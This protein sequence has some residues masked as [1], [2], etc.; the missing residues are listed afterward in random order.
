MVELTDREQQYTAH[1]FW[2]MDKMFERDTTPTEL[3]DRYFDTKDA[4]TACGYRIYVQDDPQ[5]ANSIQ[6]HHVQLCDTEI[7]YV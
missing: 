1:H 2:R 7:W 4:V 6:L 5:T 3:F